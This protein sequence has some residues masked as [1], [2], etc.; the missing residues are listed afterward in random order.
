MSNLQDQVIVIIC[1]FENYQAGRS[2]TGSFADLGDDLPQGVVRF[3]L[4]KNERDE[5][6]DSGCE[7]MQRSKTCIIM[8]FTVVLPNESHV[9]RVNHFRFVTQFLTNC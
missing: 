3:M 1:L 4:A 6:G 2:D 5:I 9:S 7:P 8:V